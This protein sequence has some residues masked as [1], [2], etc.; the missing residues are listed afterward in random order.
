MPAPSGTVPARVPSYG[1]SP[2]SPGDCPHGQ[3]CGGG[4]DFAAWRAG[5]RSGGRLS[6]KAPPAAGRPVTSLSELSLR[7]RP[8]APRRTPLP[9]TD[10]RRDGG[11]QAARFR[12]G[13]SSH[14]NARQR[15]TDLLPS[16]GYP[17]GRSRATR[18]KN[19]MSR[20]M[21]APCE[22]NHIVARIAC[23]AR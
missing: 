11:R 21:Y 10:P 23:V 20:P 15:L 4:G 12:I 17:A 2:L 14:R 6:G 13:G 18:R 22:K 1:D 9:R 5:K 3:A 16:R 8:P 7:H 19:A